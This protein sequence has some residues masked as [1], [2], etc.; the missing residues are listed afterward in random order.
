MYKPFL[1]AFLLASCGT[2]QSKPFNPD[3]AY[4]DSLLQDHHQAPSFISSDTA[5]T[6]T[7]RVYDSSVRAEYPDSTVDPMP[8]KGKQESQNIQFFHPERPMWFYGWVDGRPDSCTLSFDFKP[9]ATISQGH[10]WIPQP[11]LL[12][13][14]LQ[15]RAW[16]KNHCS[17]HLKETL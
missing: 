8:V 13:K 12:R 6:S 11:R 15:L 17:D 7:Q 5:D 14:F 2:Q 10:I 16:N 3:G 4:V 9:V 1:L